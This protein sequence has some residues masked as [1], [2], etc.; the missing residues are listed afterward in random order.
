MAVGLLPDYGG[1]CITSI[2]AVVCDAL[3]VAHDFVPLRER[4][5]EA[6]VSGVRTVAFIL[7]DGLGYRLLTRWMERHPDS[8]FHRCER[9][10]VLR[11]LTTVLPS[12]TAAALATFATGRAPA[13]HG[14]LGYKMFLREVGLIGNMIQFSPSIGGREFNANHV[15]LANFIALPSLYQKLKA[16]QVASTVCIW[17][18]Y[19]GSALSRMLYRG[20]DVQ[21]YSA[22][23][24]AFPFF[25]ERIEQNAGYVHLYWDE[26]D[27]IQ[28]Q[29]GPASGYTEAALDGLAFCLGPVAD[30]KR[31]DVLFLL[32]ADHGH[33]QTSSAQTVNL[34]DHG[35]LMRLLLTPP[36][37][38][39]RLVYL[40]PRADAVDEVA[41][42]VDEHFGHCARRVLSSQA[43][44]EGWFGEGRAHPEAR[45][46]IG[47]FVLVPEPNWKFIYPWSNDE[48]D[49]IGRHGGM[50]PEEM[51]VPL[52]AWR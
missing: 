51:E 23:H 48:R 11:K 47:H 30:W 14:L 7:V 24:D 8:A 5:P 31:D 2:A 6:L 41:G 21:G 15:N 52:L 12:T 27:V 38:D 28:H 20:A 45:S 49:A 33:V 19:K 32:T 43:L 29:Y 1:G 46:R 9:R 36:C 40:Y 42:Y 34:R 44:D 10:G 25:Q 3:G 22:C 35:R 50:D 18:G 26:M 4:L 37:G 39:A 13:Q 16:A 17:R